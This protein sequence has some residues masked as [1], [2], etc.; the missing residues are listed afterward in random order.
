MLRIM[1][2]IKIVLL[3]VEQLSVAAEDIDTLYL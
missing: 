1:S 3:I 2:S